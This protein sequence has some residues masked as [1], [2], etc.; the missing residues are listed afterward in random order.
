MLEDAARV[1]GLG[2]FGTFFRVALPLDRPA[3][4][5]VAII[6]FLQSWNLHL[7]PVAYLSDRS[8]FTLPRR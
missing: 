5:A 3:L 8:L 7:E 6:S 2:R 1:D 4:A